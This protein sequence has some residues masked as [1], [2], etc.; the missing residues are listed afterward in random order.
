MTRFV[1]TGASGLLGLNLSL[2]INQQDE[3]LGIA[4]TSPLQGLPFDIQ[5][6]D[7]VCENFQKNV[8]DHFKPDVVIHC[9]AIANLEECESN[10]ALAYETNARV[11]GEL[12]LQCRQKGV[13]FLHISTDAVFDGK[14]GNYSELDETNPLSVYA[15]TKRAAEENV[16]NH[17]PDAI[18]ARVNF[19]GWSLSGTRSLA[20][21][22]YH[23]LKSKIPI[24]GFVDIHFC[25]LYISHLS[26]LLLDMVKMDLSGIYH[27]VSSDQ[28]TKYEFGCAI[29]EQFGF[30]QALISPISVTQ[31]NLQAERSLNLTLSTNKLSKALHRSLPT[32]QDG[33][34]KFYDD[35]QNGYAQRIRDYS[36]DN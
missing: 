1:V 4:N 34:K 10:P 26:E 3:V 8:L 29:A 12:A 17:N 31:S 27:V 36:I 5:I 18:I 28:K 24:K 32:S 11:P 20:E 6:I 14:T 19:F 2:M 9:A 30:D 13:K 35:F 33:I 21:F 16:Q 22:F 25:P 15:K 23:N 7:L